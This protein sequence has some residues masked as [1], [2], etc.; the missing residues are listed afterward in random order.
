MD[1]SQLALKS[2]LDRR[3]KDFKVLPFEEG[4]A[5]P[6][7]AFEQILPGFSGDEDGHGIVHPF[8]VVPESERHVPDRIVQGALD[9]LVPDVL[10]FDQVV[11]IACAVAVLEICHCEESAGCEDSDGC[12]CYEPCIVAHLAVEFGEALSAGS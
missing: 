8:V 9:L 11:E 1:S 3:C 2:P 6:Q 10:W 5:V 12:E 4:H 7:R